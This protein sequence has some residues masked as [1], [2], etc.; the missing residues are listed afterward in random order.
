MNSKWGHYIFRI[1]LVKY[2]D[3]TLDDQE[4][5]MYDWKHCKGKIEKMSV[6]TF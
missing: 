5:T 4:T 3:F 6:M 1:F 2:L